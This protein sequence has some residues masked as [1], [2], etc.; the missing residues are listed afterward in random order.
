VNFRNVHL[1]LE[2]RHG[3]VGATGQLSIMLCSTPAQ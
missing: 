2:Y 1:W 3:D